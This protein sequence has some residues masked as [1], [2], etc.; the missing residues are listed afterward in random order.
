MFTIGSGSQK[1]RRTRTETLHLLLPPTAAQINGAGDAWV[2][3]RPV[4]FSMFTGTANPA[5]Q[6][7]FT[8]PYKINGYDGVIDGWL[9][10][11]G[12][13]LRPRTGSG[14]SFGGSERGW[15]MVVPPATQPESWHW[16][17]R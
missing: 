1:P 5:D 13:L 17:A 8:I 10:A 3:T 4:L 2:I 16:P 7:H 9:H 6:S 15:N 11:A 12:P 14:S